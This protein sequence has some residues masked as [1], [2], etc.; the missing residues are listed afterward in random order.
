MLAARGLNA[1][2]RKT[3]ACKRLGFC[4]TRRSRAVPSRTALASCRAQGEDGSK[5]EGFPA[6]HA[7]MVHTS[8]FLFDADGDGTQDIG[9]APSHTHTRKH[10]RRC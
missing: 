4:A 7:S 6:F 5:T 9:H 8:P 10:K 1:R 3:H 2:K